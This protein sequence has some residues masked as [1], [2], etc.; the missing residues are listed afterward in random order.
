M[1]KKKEDGLLFWE[2]R[3]VLEPFR[4]VWRS[5]AFLPHPY[6]ILHNTAVDQADPKK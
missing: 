4:G 5:G 2:S 1:E 3:T 6:T